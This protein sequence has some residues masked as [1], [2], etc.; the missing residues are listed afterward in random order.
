MTNPLIAPTVDSTKA[1]SGISLLETANDLSSAIESGDWAS[2]AMGAVGTALDALSVAMDP[3]GAILAAGVSWLMEHVGPLKDALNGLT[4]NADQIKAQSETWANVAKEL[5]SVAD[6]LNSAVSSDLQ[7]WSGDA[8][9]AYRQRAQDLG[10]TLQAAQKGCEGASSGVKTAGE[11]VAA[12][13]TLVRDII[14]ELVGHL[15]SWALQVVFTLGV[16]LAWVVPQVVSAVA[17]TASQITSIVTKLVKALKALIPLLKKAGTLFEDAGKAL[18]GLKGGKVSSAGKGGDVGGMPKDPPKPVGG[19]GGTPK[20][21]GDGAPPPAKSGGDDSTHS[22]SAG[23]GGSHG[24]GGTPPPPA[25]SGGDDATHVSGTGGG[26]TPPPPKSDPPPPPKTDPDPA[27]SSADAPP[28]GG[29]PKGTPGTPPPS[30]KPGNPRDTAVSKD[31]LVCKSDPVDVVRGTVV[32]EQVDLRLP[33][34]LVLE[35]LHLSS[36]RAGRW[37]GPTWTSTVDQRLELDARN[38]TFYS[39][40]GTILVYPLPAPGSPVQPAEGPRRP[41][42]V[43]DD[44]TYTVTDPLRGTELRFGRLSGRGGDVLPVAE[45]TGRGGERV[46]VEYD[47]LGAPKLLKHST[48][49]LVELD[50]DAGRIT[51]L[52]VLDETR[53]L[54]VLARSFGYDELGRLTRVINSSGLAE[55]YDYDAEGRITGWQD[56]NGVWYRYVYDAEGR[57]VRTVG[58]RGFYDGQFDYDRERRITTYTDSVGHRTQFHLN[59]ADQVV[60]EVG[61]L[62][63]TTVSTWDRYDRLLSR[64]DG[65]GRTT[66]FEYTGEGLLTAVVRPDGSRAEVE[67]GAD[68]SLTLTVTSGDRTYRRVFPT[69]EAPDLFAVRATAGTEFQQDRQWT[70]EVAPAPAQDP[71]ER[72]LFGRPRVVTD[73]SGGRTRLGWTVEGRRASR[74]G[75]TGR[76]EEWRYDAEGNVVEHAGVRYEYGPFDLTVAKIEPTGARTSYE[77]D[78]E[79]RLTRVTNPAGLS[80]SYTYDAA[81]RTVSETDFDGRVL[82]FE[83]DDAGQLVKSVD[84]LGAATT[85]VY[86]ALG[87]VVERRTPAGVTTYVYDPVGFLVRATE[88]DSVV[89]IERDESGRVVRESIDGRAVTYAYDEARVQRLTPSGV[90]SAWTYA[91]DGTPATLSVAGQLVTFRHDEAGRE[92]ERTTGTGTTL[93]QTFDGEHQLTRQVVTAR[94]TARVIQQRGYQYA[95]D[96]RVVGIDDALSGPVRFRLDQAGRVTD[97]AAP[98]GTESYRYDAAGNIVTA[99]LPAAEIGPRRYTGN[100][101][102]AAG[103]VRYSYDAQGRLTA[104]HE[105]GRTSTYRWGP[106]DRLTGVRTPDGTEWRY[107]YDPLGRRVAKQRLAPD[108]SVAEEVTFAWSGQLLVEQVH[109]DA[110][111]R[112]LVLTWDHYPDS[113]RPVTQTEHLG[114]GVRFFSFVTDQIGTPVDMI[115]AHGVVAWHGT[116]SLWGRVKP[117]RPG[118]VST[119]LRFPGQYADDETG[120]HYNVFRYYD[121]GT[122][123]YL[124][125]DPLG[126]SPAPNPIAYVPNPLSEADPLGLGCSQSK[127]DDT[128]TPPPTPAPPP[129]P[130]TNAGSDATHVQNSNPTPNP[131]SAPPP[132][133]P[134]PPPPNI[135]SKLPGSGDAAPPPPPPPPPPPTRGL[136]GDTKPSG[137]G[138]SA[139]PP[140]PPPPPPPAKGG[141]NVPGGNDGAPPP[142]PPPPPPAR[143][144]AGSG[145][146]APPPPPP[147]PP[148]AKGGSNVPGGNDGA[149]PPPPPPPPGRPHGGGDGAPPPPPPPPPPGHAH[150]GGDGPSTSGDH[151]T[152][153]TPNDHHG[154]DTT[155]HHGDDTPSHDHGDTTGNNHDGHDNTSHDGTGHDSTGHHDAEGGQSHSGGNQGGHT[156]TPYKP[157]GQDHP[158][159][160]RPDKD[161]RPFEDKYE[162]YKNELGINGPQKTLNIP[163][164][165]RI[166]LNTKIEDLPP[167]VAHGFGPEDGGKTV[168]EFMG[169][170]PEQ[171]ADVNPD[172]GK[173][174]GDSTGH[175]ILGLQGGGGYNHH[176]GTINIKAGEGDKTLYHEMGHIKQDQLGYNQGNTQKSVIEYHNVLHHENNFD[177][178]KPPRTDY[179]LGDVVGKANKNRT[180]DQMLDHVN[181]LPDDHPK[182][183]Q[184]QNAL[185]DI[186]NVLNNDPRYANN[187]NKI[188]TNLASEYFWD[189]KQGKY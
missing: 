46:V 96:G 95:A 140:P 131:A 151:H 4:G 144:H 146:S 15:I 127:P 128:D 52:R 16:G 174:F 73:A 2:V 1:Y 30:P 103:A 126:L 62:G 109:R 161:D 169:Y 21:G 159:H 71:V 147:P 167:G 78:T 177:L 175:D 181:N 41:L 57:C 33:D 162:S 120:F 104:R 158:G 189:T 69:G 99:Q 7:A 26:D 132:P 156:G 118:T 125:Q 187:A 35:R 123:R 130:R 180:W 117:S 11:V 142:P 6:D 40:D 107:R 8:S 25:K 173:P 53:N 139:P 179:T 79:L 186:E 74:I 113:T 12:V 141:S 85:Y 22:S 20:G 164:D 59:E 133:P 94:D 83:Y 100:T 172:T 36:Y 67:S 176:S 112:Q 77:Y 75:P 124:S 93:A 58:D 110:Q 66:E 29:T 152:D 91:P 68:G 165:P 153:T 80:W 63:E 44:G 88:G 138:D 184:T 65:L 121:P 116:T 115:D 34:P 97:V 155:T 119:P 106:L 72:D 171:L 23:G 92:V 61:P 45:L 178:N 43:A 55:T 28:P 90:D 105:N 18:K 19:G 101:L 56:R 31:N 82:R 163:D 86:D 122:G 64:T 102:A 38:A 47:P 49:Y 10:T 70:A 60:R 76:Q 114:T 183:T 17:K 27:P 81:G 37:F 129:P 157:P 145:D 3:F 48:G 111:G 135:G 166:T 32:L 149:P 84:G 148:P 9:D 136:G 54:T 98:S 42:A 50:T 154:N 87:N 150:S 168:G 5:G 89:E 39:A 185:D 24:G 182:K 160:N 170:K 13:R 108:G 188:K 137:S 51:A 134:P 143:P 14:S